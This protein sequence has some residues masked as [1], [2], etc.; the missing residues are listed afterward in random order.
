MAV[1]PVHASPGQPVKLLVQIY[2]HLTLYMRHQVL[3][4]N[5]ILQLECT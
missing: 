4:C 3:L 2:G 1:R 5:R